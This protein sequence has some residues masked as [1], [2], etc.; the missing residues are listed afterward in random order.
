MSKKEKDRK[1][2]QKQQQWER[3]KAEIEDRR[4]KAPQV[5]AAL[6]VKGCVLPFYDALDSAEEEFKRLAHWAKA[7]FRSLHE[8]FEVG[9]EQFGEDW[10]QLGLPADWEQ[11]QFDCDD[12]RAASYMV[13]DTKA[14]LRG[15]TTGFFDGSGGFHT[16]IQIS[17]NPA[18]HWEHKEHKYLF[19][20]PGLLHEIGHVK[21]FEEK[22]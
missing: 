22:I 17:K 13:R 5:K 2:Q 1:R 19:K 18:C 8:V 4:R 6:R 14:N 9:A 20:L 15:S 7:T 16:V 21:D 10:R 12:E 11:I 3:E